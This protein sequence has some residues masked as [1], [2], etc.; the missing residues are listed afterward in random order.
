MFFVVHYRW[1]LTKIPFTANGR[2]CSKQDVDKTTQ[3]DSKLDDTTQ[4][5]QAPELKNSAGFRAHEDAVAEEE[6]FY[7]DDVTTS[8][9]EEESEDES[10]DEDEE[11]TP[12]GFPIAVYGPPPVGILGQM[13]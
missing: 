10:S 2:T 11:L 8:E 4:A 1:N 5:P 6:D 9:S 13:F 3:T 7:W 12:D